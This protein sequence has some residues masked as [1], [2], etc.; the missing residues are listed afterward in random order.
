[1]SAPSN[2]KHQDTPPLELSEAEKLK[3]GTHRKAALG[4]LQERNTG[5]H[6]DERC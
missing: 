5:G 4:E 3:E 1:M 2:E 6:G